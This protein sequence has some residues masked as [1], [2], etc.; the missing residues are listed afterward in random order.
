MDTPTYDQ[1]VKEVVTR[2]ESEIILFFVILLFILVAAVIPMYRMVLKDRKERLMHENTRQDKYIEREKQVI[3]V[4][5]GVIT[6]NTEVIA[7]LKSTLELS[8]TST[9]DSLARIHDRVDGQYRNCADHGAALARIQST[10]DEIVRGQQPID[11][12]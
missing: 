6:R 11:R 7:E 5:T 4:I 9:S 1:I 12:R 2:T 3:G 8:R 10:L